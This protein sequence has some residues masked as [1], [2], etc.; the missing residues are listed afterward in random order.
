M[1]VVFI[2]AGAGKD[3]F[4]TVMDIEDKLD[5][6]YKLIGCDL[7]EI[8]IRKIGNKFFSIVCDEEGL[9]KNNSISS[10]YCQATGEIFVGNLVICG[11]SRNGNLTGL[12]DADIIQI[13]D[14]IVP[15]KVH[16][17]DLFVITTTYS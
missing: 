15:V 8:P 3:E 16:A 11:Q 10:C 17:K 7:I 1:Q 4:A 14:S 2:K 5:T 6:Y 9:L 12:N 13:R